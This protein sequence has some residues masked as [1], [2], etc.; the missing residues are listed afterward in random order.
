MF[1]LGAL[2]ALAIAG[3]LCGCQGA[4]GRRATHMA[5][6]EQY[7]TQG[8]FE[9][10]RIEFGN[11]LQIAPND[12]QA[13]LMS[14]RVAE[15]LGNIRAALGFYQATLD[16]D[17]RD[18][19]ARASLA[20]LLVLGGAADRALEI[21]GAGLAQH[22]DDPELLTV[23]GAARARL[24]DNAGALAD[25]EHA[26]TVAPSNADAAALLAALY[27]QAGQPDRAVELLQATIARV[28]G[29]VDLRQILADLYLS[30]GKESL[31]QELLLTIVRMRPQDL[32]FRKQL[33]GFY[34]R[35]NRL[36]D[37]E[38]VL[39][40]TL[41]WA[42]DSVDAQ[43]AYVEFLAAHRSWTR[44]E[45]VMAEL[46]ARRP[47]D[48]DLRLGFGS[49]EQRFGATQN[50]IATYR[51]VMAQD[52]T[53]P[54]GLAARNRLAALEVAAGQ[55][56]QALTLV[57][58]VL[59][60][61]P[62]DL[63]ALTIR[64]NLQLQR[65][66]VAGAIADL[67]AVLREQPTSIPVLR[68]LA[69]AHLAN[70]DPALAEESL[71]SA[72]DA[73][74]TDTAVRVELAQLYL[75]KADLGA[76][77]T[78]IQQLEALDPKLAAGP[79]LSGQLASAEDRWPEAEREFE[80]ALQLQPAAIDAL[81]ALTQLELARGQADAAL[82]RVRALLASDPNNAR[83]LNLMGE[84]CLSSNHLSEAGTVLARAIQLAPRWWLP[85][86]NLAHVKLETSDL[87]G[88]VATEEA[89]LR[90]SNE[91]AL[92]ADVAELY[93]RQGRVE[94][95]IRQYEALHA[96]NPHADLV[97]NNLAMLLV[98]H[99]TDR[100]SLERARELTSSFARSDNPALLD[101]RGW[102]L[103]K[104]GELAEALSDLEQ[105]AARRP[106]SQVIRYHL[107]MAQLKAGQR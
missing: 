62:R 54:H 80:R 98:N 64:G 18:L 3:V 26:F 11:A 24:K 25:A 60:N 52:H 2:A 79:Y 30:T 81:A 107:G 99:R 43:L 32:R 57:S 106:D 31:A 34:T 46:S 27:K 42:P 37:A 56:E 21:V 82:A 23:R 69:R 97:A 92:M 40:E 58:E 39:K 72:L 38:R 7:F 10:A 87:A 17:S 76:A 53:G 16:I 85:Y 65:G 86:R 73:S 4:E 29:S 84:L 35:S 14:G 74:P 101:T 48:Y 83:A 20:R 95:A 49:L 41:S 105:A 67:R 8:N 94:A 19:L 22:P 77:R 63:D 70:G 96:R 33:A 66:N 28:P 91:A 88:A 9:K 103:F 102:V 78:A 6:G 89:G 12:A 71:R 1:G 100:S 75:Q 61:N 44:A 90:Q 55:Y 51:S 15:K 45:A 5:R 68:S 36:D 47:K 59:Q 104:R 50:A 13:R 93:E